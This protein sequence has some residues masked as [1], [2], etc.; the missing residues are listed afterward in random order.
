MQLHKTA[1]V[2]AGFL[3]LFLVPVHFSSQV[4]SANLTS[5]KITLSTPRFSFN[6]LLDNTNS[7]GGSTINI[8][9]TPGITASTTSAQLFEGDAVLIGLGHYRVRSVAPNGSFEIDT[10]LLAGDA[11]LNDQVVSSRSATVTANFSTV[12]P[13]S[14]GKFRIL[15]PA[16]VGASGNDAIPDQTG[17]DF[18]GGSNSSVSVVCPDDLS[19]GGD[20]YDFVSGIASAS[21]IVRAGRTY[22]VFTCPYSGTGGSST[23]FNTTNKQFIINDLINP[24]PASE[25]SEGYGDTYR[26]VVE[27][28]EGNDTIVD[29]TSTVVA[30]IESVRIS[31]SVAEQITF[32]VSGIAAGT[33]MCSNA[34][35]VAT[36]STTVPLGELLSNAFKHAA[37]ELAVTTNADNGY[38][39]TAIES[40]QLKRASAACAGDAT[41]GGC[42]PDSK[43][44]NVTMS[45]TV[46][47][48]WVDTAN[49]GF[50][51]SLQGGTA[52]SVAFAHSTNSGT[53]DGTAGSC[54]K[55]FADEEDIQTA[56]QIFS[57]ATVA[58]NESANVC[59]K[60]V[61]ASTQEAGSDYTTTI[62]YRA[63]ASF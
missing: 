17:W 13:I 11:D 18:G 47:D 21:A 7:V 28:L 59:Y 41:T 37:Q 15:I 25:H 60:A 1:L 46:F 32:R 51:Y 36:T 58:D 30:V 29:S 50:A 54:Y 40:N 35:S 3:A 57:S 12:T 33:T 23:T 38:A 56:Q 9:T 49:K 53:C 48:K 22:H 42:I 44:D 39:V 52:A 14:N 4:R 8:R 16:A 20:D 55:Q 2:V 19:S 43:G 10:T 24:S 61:I 63:T 31:A 26:I 27:Q 6:G 5:V 62:T 45:H 34:T